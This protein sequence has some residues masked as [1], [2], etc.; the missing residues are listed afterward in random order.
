MW[1]WQFELFYPTSFQCRKF[2]YYSLLMS[3][4]ARKNGKHD[5]FYQSMVILTK[6]QCCFVNLR[7]IYFWKQGCLRIHNCADTFHAKDLDC[8]HFNGLAKCLLSLG[9]K[10]KRCN[11]FWA[12]FRRKRDRPK[13]YFLMWN[14]LKRRSEQHIRYGKSSNFN[15]K[16][17]KKEKKRKKKKN[18]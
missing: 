7:K 18:S 14:N 13:I 5:Y 9:K 11:N 1:Q 15:L 3:A 6:K 12:S 17:K 2:K 10:N 16:K 8:A 4:K